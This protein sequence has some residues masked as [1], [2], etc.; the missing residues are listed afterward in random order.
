MGRIV[1][2]VADSKESSKVQSDK[3]KYT[4]LSSCWT[5]EPTMQKKCR[6]PPFYRDCDRHKN[7]SAQTHVEEGKN[8]MLGEEKIFFFSDITL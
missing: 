7:G 8:E 4:T 6:G 5:K 3:S 1:E 2:R